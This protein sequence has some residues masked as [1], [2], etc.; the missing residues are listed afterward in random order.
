MTAPSRRHLLA[1]TP[2]LALFAMGCPRIGNPDI[3]KLGDALKRFLPKV[4]FDRVNIREIDFKKADL[5]FLFKVRNPAPLKV[6]LSSFSYALSLEDTPLF[7]GNNPEGV[8]LRP[9]ATAPLR[10]PMTIRWADLAQLLQTTHGRDELGFALS[11]HM[12]FQT[13]AG[14]AR[15]PYDAGGTVPALR[16]PRFTLRDI[17]VEEFRPRENRARVGINLGVT[18]FGGST[19]SFQRFDYRLRFGGNDVASGMVD[20]LGEVAAD[21]SGRLTLPVDVSLTGVGTSI[22]DAISRKGRLDA[23][24]EAGLEVGTP[25]GAVPLSIDRSKRLQ[26]R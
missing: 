2:G 22:I 18:N 17:K 23:R 15:L 12:G 25:F 24:L 7:Q 6:A 14:E 4:R 13:P 5:T 1:A 9:E 21:A 19:F 10:F 3:E 8:T 16:R 11:G 20:R 26:V